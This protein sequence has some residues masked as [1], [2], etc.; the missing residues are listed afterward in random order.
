MMEI[1]IVR[2]LDQDG[3]YLAPPGSEGTWT[4]DARKAQRFTTR[5]ASAAVCC[6]NETP[7]LL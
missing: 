4:K 3:G 2:R 7:E 6:E 5:E 1:W